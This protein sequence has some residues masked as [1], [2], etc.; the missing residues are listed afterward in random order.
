MTPEEKRLSLEQQLAEYDGKLRRRF[1]LGIAAA[2]HCLLL[3]RHYAESPYIYFSL[4]P[5]FPRA[6]FARNGA[7]LD[8]S[9]SGEC[10]VPFANSAELRRQ[11]VYLHNCQRFFG[12]HPVLDEWINAQVTSAFLVPWRTRNTSELYLLN[13]QTE[14]LLFGYARALVRQIIGHHRARLLIAAGKSSLALLNDLG[15]PE[16]PVRVD[17]YFGPGGSYQWSRC[18]AEVNGSRLTILQIPHFSRANSPSKLRELGVWLTDEL[19]RFGE[20]RRT[21]PVPRTNSTAL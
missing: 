6:G 17:R 11:Y 14:G 20:E 13:R 4:N 15:V 9:S 21:G 3:G 1:G 10:N 7:P 2:G 16:R 12:A 5:G 18:E 19:A 8:P